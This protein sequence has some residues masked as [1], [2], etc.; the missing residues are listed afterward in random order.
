[1]Q[2]VEI[3]LESGRRFVALADDEAVEPS[4]EP[5]A[6]SRE[7]IVAEN[8]DEVTWGVDDPVESVETLE[9][10]VDMHGVEARALQAGQ[11][12]V[13][14]TPETWDLFRTVGVVNGIE[15][16][17]RPADDKFGPAMPALPG[18]SS[19]SPR[20]DEEMSAAYIDAAMLGRDLIN[21]PEFLEDDRIDAAF[22]RQSVEQLDPAVRAKAIQNLM[23]DDER[24]ATYTALREAV[25][26]LL[27]QHRDTSSDLLRGMLWEQADRFGRVMQLFVAKE[28]N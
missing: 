11:I 13:Q 4:K 25:D 8:A 23:T 9:S 16:F 6:P 27:A 26:L 21:S 12:M 14:M 2:K 19:P 3:V 24:L 28:G 7:Q 5:G 10:P 1:M 17:V 15:W 22:L 20:R 18:R